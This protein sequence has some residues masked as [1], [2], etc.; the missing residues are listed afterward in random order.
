MALDF[1]GGQKIAIGYVGKLQ[2]KVR[3]N[4]SLPSKV[5][6]AQGQV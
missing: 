4:V 5:I 3:P 6:Q 1:A 2:T